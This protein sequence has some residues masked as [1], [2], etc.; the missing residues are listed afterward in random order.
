ML[1][2]HPHHRR[3]ALGTATRSQDPPIAEI[4]DR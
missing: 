2:R 1:A 3:L 4:G